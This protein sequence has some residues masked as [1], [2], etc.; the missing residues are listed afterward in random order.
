MDFN[1]IYA[2]AWMSAIRPAEAELIRRLGI[3]FGGSNSVSAGL[4][5]R[6]GKACRF[7]ILNIPNLRLS[8][9]CRVI[10]AF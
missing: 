3:F 9:I 1:S 8:A 4:P 7:T 10:G 5:G 2:I 6:S